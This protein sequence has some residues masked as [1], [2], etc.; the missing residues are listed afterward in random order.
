[1]QFSGLRRRVSVQLAQFLHTP[2]WLTPLPAH[3]TVVSGGFARYAPES[4]SMPDVAPTEVKHLT[5]D[6]G[7]LIRVVVFSLTVGAAMWASTTS[8]RSDVRNIVTTL[9]Y[10]QKLD[11]LQGQRWTDQLLN[12]KTAIDQMKAR[13]ELQQYEIQELKEQI[14]KLNGGRP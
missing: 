8:L 11:E 1:M 3:L 14:L 7:T 12:L 2:L 13:Q 4:A 6:M 9:E 10:Q 5:V